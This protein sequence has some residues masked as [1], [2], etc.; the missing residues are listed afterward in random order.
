MSVKKIDNVNTTKANAT[1]GSVYTIHTNKYIEHDPSK[2]ITTS[3]R[4][5]DKYQNAHI[6]AVAIDSSRRRVPEPSTLRTFCR[7]KACSG[8]SVSLV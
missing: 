8:N 6:Q 1:R 3:I 2:P 5:K 4:E 7:L